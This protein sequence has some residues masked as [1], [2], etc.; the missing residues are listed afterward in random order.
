MVDG[1]EVA[2]RQAEKVFDRPDLRDA[3][4]VKGTDGW[5]VEV[6]TDPRSPRKT[7]VRAPWLLR[8]GESGQPHDPSHQNDPMHGFLRGGEDR[9]FAPI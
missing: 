7:L 9:N 5:E 2:G 6:P 3:L 4:G 1:A 8:A